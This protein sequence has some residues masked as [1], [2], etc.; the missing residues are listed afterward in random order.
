MEKRRWV[1]ACLIAAACHSAEPP[2]PDHVAEYRAAAVERR[3]GVYPFVYDRNG[4]PLSKNADFASINTF[5]ASTRVGLHERIRTTLDPRVQRAAL[6]A[7]A[8]YKGSLVAIDPR[9]NELLAITSSDALTHQYEPGS[10]IKTLTLLTALSNGANVQF[11][12]ECKGWLDIDGRHFGDWHPGGHGTLA[13]LD[14]ALAQSCNVVF[15]DIGLKAGLDRLTA[16]HKSAGFDGDAD[17]GFFKVPLGK[18]IGPIFNDFE[19][20][21]YSIGLV[22]ESATPLHLGMLASML[23]NRGAF[24]ATPRLVVARRAFVGTSLGPPPQPPVRQLVPR[25]VAE[26]VVTAMQAVVTREK[27]TGRRAA[28][29]GT[30]LAL[31][32]GTAGTREAG[33]DAII[34]AFTPAEQPRIAFALVL[35]NAGSAELAAAKVAH[36]FITHL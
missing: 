24:A 11:P 10:V 22:H 5:L 1:I 18:T 33:Y 21:F 6:T 32:T 27:G 25:D 16:L 30:T 28:V 20:G 9:T 36:D 3:S 29:D 15:A 14:E 23:A 13:D 34:I 31:K 26:R 4:G 2:A 17:F 12:Y 19:T 7:L 8:D 35:E